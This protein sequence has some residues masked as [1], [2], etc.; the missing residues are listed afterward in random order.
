MTTAEGPREVARARAEGVDVVAE[1]CPQYLTL[2]RDEVDRV[3]GK[4]NPPLRH[5]ADVEG[6]WEGIE[7][8]LVECMGSDHAPC[9]LVHKREFW[10]ATVGFANLQT[11][12]PVLLSEGVNKGRMTLS[13]L[14]EIVCRNNARVFGLWPRKGVL[15]PGADADLVVVDLDKTVTVKAKDLFH[16]SDFTL[17]EGR[18]LKGWPVL[19]VV[20]GRVVMEEGEIVSEP[21]GRFV[22]AQAVL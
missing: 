17:Y 6:L 16:I 9:A 13:R 10:T 5:R 14:V 20:G 11:F 3:I 15:Q 19:T 2:T 4:I 21:A 22:P 1:T 18:A 7:K 12:L 8:G